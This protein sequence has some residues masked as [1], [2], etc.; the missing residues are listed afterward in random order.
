MR[1]G[2]IKGRDGSRPN[3]HREI[4]S[5]PLTFRLDV[6]Q[7]DSDGK[8]WGHSVQWQGAEA[9]TLSDPDRAMK[10]AEAILADRLRAAARQCKQ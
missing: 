5:G 6:W 8:Q 1:A 9:Q 7:V 2:W 10:A 4:V 3:Y